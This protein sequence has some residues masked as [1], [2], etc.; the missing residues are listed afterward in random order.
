[1]MAFFQLILGITIVG[2]IAG[3]I[4][5]GITLLLCVVMAVISVNKGDKKDEDK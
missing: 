3:P 1:M 2:A 5:I 4:G